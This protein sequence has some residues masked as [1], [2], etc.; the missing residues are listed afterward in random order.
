M[1]K[2]KNEFLDKYKTHDG[3]QG[4]IEKWQEAARKAFITKT[5][6]L[7][8]LENSA[9]KEEIEEK[10]TKIGRRKLQVD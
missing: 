2:K 5:K 4:D 1:A 10:L 3:E 7:I 9:T 6:L 8:E